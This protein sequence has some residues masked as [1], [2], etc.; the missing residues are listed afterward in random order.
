MSTIMWEMWQK[1]G[2]KQSVGATPKPVFA[3]GIVIPQRIAISPFDLK[4]SD[5]TAMDSSGGSGKFKWFLDSS[6]LH[7]L[8]EAAQNNTK[9]DT[10]LICLPIRP[11]FTYGKLGDITLKVQARVSGTGTLGTTKTID[12]TAKRVRNTVIGADLVTTAAQTLVKSADLTTFSFTIDADNA[13]TPLEVGDIVLIT[14][15]TSVQET[16]N[17]TTLTAL[18]GEISITPPST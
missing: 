15:T 1:F 18:L 14:I 3:N 9:T 16:A 6:N 13:T 4:N 17:S 2:V 12:A 5:G 8:G 7:I 11:G 10:L